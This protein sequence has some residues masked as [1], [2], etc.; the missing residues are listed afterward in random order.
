MTPASRVPSSDGVS[1]AVHDLGGS[2]PTLLLSHATGFHGRCYLPVAHS[3]ADR[4]HSIAFDY[5]GHG[6]TLR[7]DGPVVWDRYGDDAVAMAQS[8]DGP[9]AAFGHSMGGACLLMAAHRDP[10]LFSRLVV[11]EPIVFPPEGLRPGGGD[12]PLV[13]GARRRRASFPS[14]EA[15]IENYARKRPLGA[16][17]PEALDAYV[18]YGFAPGEDG[19]VHLK[20]RPE[21]EAATF[22]TGGTH[23]TWDDLPATTVPV[24]VVSG[25]VQEMQPSHIAESIAER[26]PNAT[27]L[28]VAAFD[29]FAPMTHPAE[30][31]EVIA[32]FLLG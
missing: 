28:E 20:C 9:I 4:F 6:D 17:T 31:A 30:M 24:L 12:S 19:E 7:P 11:F 21:T 32:D 15:A 18:R 5:R 3:L 22:E 14:Y 23:A 10:S 25:V 26:L 13:A 16:F 2:G 29:H 1:L 27:Y 8:F